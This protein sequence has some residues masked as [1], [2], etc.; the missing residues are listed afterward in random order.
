MGRLVGEKCCSLSLK[1]RFTNISS[2]IYEKL[3]IK[4]RNDKK[5]RSNLSE[6]YA[7]LLCWSGTVIRTHPRCTR[8]RGGG[9][10]LYEGCTGRRRGLML[11][12][13]CYF[14]SQ[15]APSHPGRRHQ[16]NSFCRPFTN[17]YPP[18]Q[19]HMLLPTETTTSRPL[20]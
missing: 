1:R 15:G 20:S 16:C 8:R 2:D 3:W 11:L 4:V 14:V 12:A 5:V 17:L 13:A 18:L 19:L 9:G 7:H 6:K 10:G